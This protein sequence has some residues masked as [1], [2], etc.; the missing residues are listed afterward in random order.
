MR[1]L[2]FSTLALNA[3]ARSPSAG[4][5]AGVDG[6][7]L[8][9]ILRRHRRAELDRRLREAAR[10]DEV[11]Q[12]LG[13]Q[14]PDVRDVADVAVEERDPAGR[15]QRLEHEAPARAELVERELEEPQQVARL[16]VLDDLRG[17]DAAERG[18]GQRRRVADGVRFGDVEAARA[19]D[20]RHLVIQIDAARADAARGEQIEELAAAA[21]DVEHVGRAVEERQVDLE[22]RADHLA[23]A[24]E[25]ILEA[26]V[27]VGVEGRRR[28]RHRQQAPGPI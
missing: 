17:E 12:R 2:S 18:V 28:R 15:V 25:L 3:S 1:A 4:V 13:V 14:R 24:P 21:A 9:A 11:L 26:D 5:G 8:Q 16:Q 6:D 27:L 20:L 7:R 19:A 10:D 22:P 23:R